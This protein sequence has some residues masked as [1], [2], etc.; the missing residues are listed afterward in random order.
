[1]RLTVL[2]GSSFVVCDERGDLGGDVAASG[3]FA[4]DTRFLSRS[5]LTIDGERGEPVSFEQ[6][7]PHVGVFDLR[8][9]SG[10]EVRRELFVG[11]GFEETVTVSNRS[12]REVEAV[13]ALDLASDFADIFAVKR[14]ED[15]GA[16]GT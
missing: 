10:L 4:A 11:G 7:A 12:E 14:V 16:P 2:D 6:G 9:S 5:V 1:M 3:F 8:W 13:L 15:L